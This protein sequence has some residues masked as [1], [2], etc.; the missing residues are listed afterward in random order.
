MARN[1]KLNRMKG[2]CK[3]FYNH[4][5]YGFIQCDD[6]SGDLFVHFSEINS[7][8]FKTLRPGQSVEFDIVEQDNGKRKAINV[9]APNQSPITNNYNDDSD[10]FDTTIKKYNL[11]SPSP[12]CDI[13]ANLSDKLYLQNNYL[14]QVLIRSNKMNVNKLLILGLDRYQWNTS[15]LSCNKYQKMNILYYG[16]GIHPHN[17]SKNGNN[18]IDLE[19]ELMKFYKENSK[20]NKLVCIGECGLDYN[21]MFSTKKDQCN[22][23]RQHVRVALKLKLP[24]VCHEREGFDDFIKIVSEE[25]KLFSNKKQDEKKNDN[26]QMLPIPII[27]HCFTGTQKELKTHV[28]MGFYI[29]ITTF[30]CIDYRAKELRRC[31]K[32]G[33][34]PLDKLLIETDAPF[35]KPQFNQIE[36]NEKYELITKYFNKQGNGKNNIRKKKFKI[37]NEPCLLPTLL[38]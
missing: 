14:S 9:T 7:S 35:M 30:L 19:N 34:L 3:V 6:G 16:I 33:I 36:G 24:L 31:I 13:C 2:I 10:T 26:T 17:A 1:V 8:S 22:V 28:S 23:F 37:R 11:P 18:K 27:M 25:I 32:S 12:I 38:N 29:G 20:E 21:R 5:G 15:K 4:K